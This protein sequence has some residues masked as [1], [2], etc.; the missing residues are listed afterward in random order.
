MEQ[1]AVGPIQVL[2]QF[3]ALCHRC[4]G[5]ANTYI[6]V[7]SSIISGLLNRVGAE[8]CFLIRV[9]D[10]YIDNNSD[11]RYHIS[12]ISDSRIVHVPVTV[13]PPV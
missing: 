6:I 13:N 7:P 1:R 3:P 11:L 5:Y 4:R 12:L 9:H 2:A 10:T 8:G